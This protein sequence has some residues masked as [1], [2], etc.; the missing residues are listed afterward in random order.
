F[1]VYMS[2][3]GKP[4]PYSVDN[5]PYKSKHH[6]P[7]SIK[8]V[9]NNDFAMIMGYP[10]RTDRYLTSYG[11]KL[12]I[13]KDQ[14]A[15]VKIREKR[16]S[17]MKEEMDKSDEVRIQYASTYAQVSNYYKYF[18]GQTRGL[19][20]LSVYDKKRDLEDEF[21]AWI[22]AE[23][24]RKDL[25]SQAIPDIAAAYAML[26]DY[27]L[28]QVYLQEAI[29]GCEI[30]AF[31]A[32]FMA[33]SG[34]LSNKEAKEEETQAIIAQLREVAKDHFKNY[35]VPTDKKVTAAMFAYFS[36]DIAKDLQ[37]DI[38]NTI[39]SKYK[40]DFKKYAED[41]FSKSI[42]ADQEK[43]N[44]F[45]DKPSAKIID[46]DPAMIALKSVFTNYQTKV[47]PVIMQ[48]NEKLEK[49]NRLLVDGLR[50]MKTDKKFYPNANFTMRLTYGKVGNYFPQ[51][52]MFYKHYTTA[53]GIIEKEDPKDDEFIVPAKLKDLILRKDFGR[54]ADKNGD[55]VVG[56]ISDNDIT[57]GNSG[58]P[59]IN[60]DGHLIGC[61][62]DG[63]WEAMS[64]DIA[65]ETELQRTI[66]VDARY[67]L[68]IVDK[69]AGATNLIEEMTII[70]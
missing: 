63:N 46:K 54:Y 56:F 1:R 14:P 38:F 28:S 51:D 44:K 47:Q 16:L 22:G 7:V 64:G 48:S 13:E 70:E 49:G 67:I 50:N 34:H 69:F 32:N 59:V 37:P 25:Y 33:L 18:K 62:F 30:I 9:E 45:L 10:G 35:N 53:D 57:G 68:F 23:E 3:D 19:K 5:V 65:F 31:T 12:A 55:L 15:R 36:S 4:A 20:R 40:G 41:L 17:L 27:K 2:A 8:G 60:G 6:L 39:E 26:E 66:S 21:V 42:F 29:F 24:S 58:S 11:V 61:A 43:L 52:A